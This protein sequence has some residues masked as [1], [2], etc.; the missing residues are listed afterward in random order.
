MSSYD[1][2]SQSM[3][4]LSS[5]RSF[6]TRSQATINVTNPIFIKLLD[7]VDDPYWKLILLDAAKGK[8]PKGFS[9]NGSTLLYRL[10]NKSITIEDNVNSINRFIEFIRMNTGIRSKMDLERE[11]DYERE[12]QISP[13]NVDNWG[14]IKSKFNKRMIV[15]E[16]VT[17]TKKLY[18]LSEEEADQLTTL[19]NMNLEEDVIK[20]NIVMKDNNI[21]QIHGLHWD[22]IKRKFFLEG[23]PK[24]IP[25]SGGNP[26]D[27]TYVEEGIPL[28]T[29]HVETVKNWNKFLK[30]FNKLVRKSSS[31]REE[32]G[33]NMSTETLKSSS[34][35][36]R[37]SNS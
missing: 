17:K 15:I 26:A 1:S 8:F 32:K 23:E 19:I 9:F 7:Y 35:V 4:W 25:F 12:H 11:K 37:S 6:S 21:V 3:P 31:S 36:T 5:T 28:E 2:T 16:F 13:S 27:V 33:L 30:E 18:N 29:N 10:N 20:K 14:K 22:P 34:D 24:R